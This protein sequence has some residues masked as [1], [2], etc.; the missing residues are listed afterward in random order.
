MAILAMEFQR[1]PPRRML[2][3][4]LPGGIGLSEFEKIPSIVDKVTRTW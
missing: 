3:N 1:H 2:K 4:D